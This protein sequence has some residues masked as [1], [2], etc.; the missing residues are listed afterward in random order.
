MGAARPEA[1]RFLTRFA[2]DLVGPDVEIGVH[3]HDTFGLS[4]ANAMAA[5][6]AGA[7][8]VDAVPLGLGDGA[9]I[10]ASEEVSAAVEVLYGIPT[11]VKLD[12]LRPLCE[13]VAQAFNL[14]MQKTKAVVGEHTYHHQIDSHVAAILRGAW[15]AWEVARPEVLGHQRRLAFGNSKVRDGRSGAV[16]ALL[17]KMGVD[18]SDEQLTAVI[19]A[20]RAETQRRGTLDIEAA[21]ALVRQ[22]LAINGGER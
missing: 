22:V 19:A 1:I 2:R 10:T 9:G 11:G 20:L 6:T 18:A 13:Q 4:L 8:L 15:Y 12:Q 17:G 3:V 5:L 7:S 21:E 14:P 16:A